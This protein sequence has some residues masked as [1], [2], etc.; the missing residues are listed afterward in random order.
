[1]KDTRAWIALL[2]LM[3]FLV[4][5]AS[6]VLHQR[7]TERPAERGPFSAYADRLVEQFELSP[8]RAHHLR[9]VLR[10][11]AQE[12]DRI[13]DARQLEFYATLEKELRPKGAEYNRIIR[14][15][16]LPPEQRPDFDRLVAGEGVPTGTAK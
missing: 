5:V 2:A 9:V 4:G 15:V 12:V 6:T 14:D 11:Y 13:R 8:E 7:L 1:M 10:D 16:V 3:S